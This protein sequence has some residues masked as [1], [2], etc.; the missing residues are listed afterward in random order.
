MNT[1][2]KRI[3][4][5][6]ERLKDALISLVIERGY[7]GITIQDVTAK[8][9]VGYRT[10]FRH[11]DGLDDLLLS[12]LRE[13]FTEMQDRMVDPNTHLAPER[14]GQLLFEYVLKNRDLFLVMVRSN[15]IRDMLP[16]LQENVLNAF[17]GMFPHDI[18]NLDL[19]L[20]TY[21]IITSILSLIAWWLENDL[22]RSP[23][24][25]GRIYAQLIMYPSRRMLEK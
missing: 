6:R 4:K 15:F 11:Y 12:I 25:M 21:H 2:D 8:A 5:T 23:E 3:Q 19:D 14:N 13:Q 24:E 20:V 16:D 18:D 22:P 10:F 17:S 9:E 1:L 7:D